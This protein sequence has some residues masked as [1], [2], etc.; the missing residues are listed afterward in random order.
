[1]NHRTLTLAA[2]VV[3][4]LSAGSAE[5]VTSP[6]DATCRSGLMLA[7][8]RLTFH[9]IR[10]MGQCHVQRARGR[11]RSDVDCNNPDNVPYPQAI[12]RIQR[13]VAQLAKTQ[14]RGASLPATLG[15]TTCPAPCGSG[16]LTSYQGDVADCLVCRARAAASATMASTLGE[17]PVTGPH[18]FETF[19]VE[20]MATGIRKFVSKRLEQQRHCQFLHDRGRVSQT[21]DCR[22]GDLKGQVAR[23]QQMVRYYLQR[24]KGSSRAS[25]IECGEGD[26]DAASSCVAEI[27]ESNAAALF[28]TVYSQP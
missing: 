11:I 5:A 20:S 2:I 28:D 10:Q 27:V 14:C 9:L 16:P 19:C 6:A 18:T 13:S 4:M 8:R 21:T 12:A 25:V 7:E 26:L 22:S 24:C 23:S 3:L 1:M 17:P 15:F